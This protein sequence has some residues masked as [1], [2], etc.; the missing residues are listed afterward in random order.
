LNIFSKLFGGKDHNLG[1]TYE[2]MPLE[3][4]VEVRVRRKIGEDSEGNPI[5]GDWEPPIKVCNLSTDDGQDFIAEQ[6][7]STS[8]GSN[9]ANYIALSEGTTDE[10]ETS[11]T[12]EEEITTGGLARAQGSY[13]H[14]TGAN[15]FTVSHTFT[16][17]ASFTVHKS[18]LF[19]ASSGGTMVWVANFTNDAS[20][21]SG[22]QLQ[23]TWTV[24]G[25]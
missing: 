20:L 3:G 7:G 22:D 4:N 19:T 5:Y 24:S 25:F 9:G 2:N 10:T 21:I 14:T 11:S 12:L 6:L 16:A 17:S 18:A 1:G 13:N 8:P 15:S 23:V